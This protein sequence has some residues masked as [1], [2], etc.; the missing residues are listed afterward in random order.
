[1]AEKLCFN[2]IMTNEA[3]LVNHFGYVCRF[4]H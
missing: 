2:T 3:P 1:M 4:G